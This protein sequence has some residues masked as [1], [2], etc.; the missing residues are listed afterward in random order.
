M[1][2]VCNQ[3]LVLSLLLWM[4]MEFTYFVVIILICLDVFLIFVDGVSKFL[5]SCFIMGI[6]VVALA[7]VIMLLMSNWYLVVFL[8]QISCTNISLQYVNSLNCMVSSGVGMTYDACY[9]G[10]EPSIVM[11]SMGDVCT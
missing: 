10:F 7:Y 8:A 6:C 1:L 3:L 4:S 2:D 5:S 9:G 11:A